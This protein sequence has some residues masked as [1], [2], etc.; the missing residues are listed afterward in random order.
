M[1]LQR[2][3]HP[4]SLPLCKNSKGSFSL[5][6]GSLIV[7]PLQVIIHSPEEHLEEFKKIMAHVIK[8]ATCDLSYDVRDRARF[9]S[10]LLPYSTTYLN[11][12]NSSCQSHNEDMFKELAN[13]I[14]DGKM[15]STFHP[16]NNYRIYLPGSLSQVVLHAAPG[17]APLPK[18]Q[19]MELIHKTMEPTR[20]VGNS[21]ES[22]NS[23][24]ESGSSTY[25]SG[26]VYDSESEV[27]GSSDRNAA[28]SNTKDNQEDPLVHVYDASVDQGQTARDVEDNFASLI[29]TDLT[30]LMSKSALE[31]WLDE[32]PAEPVQVSTQA[33]SAR[34]SFTNRSFERKPKLHMLLDPSNSN[35][36]SVL[37]AFSSEVS[38]VSR[39]LV[40]V[41]LLFENVST[42]QLADITI[43]SEEASGSEDG[44][45]QTLQG[46][47]RYYPSLIGSF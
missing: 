30:E 22:I 29:T 34:V 39:L 26:S 4:P 23:D 46:S 15:P 41:D 8:L 38:P 24:A 5:L 44:L 21:S 40:C 1:L 14:F 12:N 31:T 13:H 36:L 6:W 35:G 11:G 47:A 43:K 18:P 17:Y 45:D 16:T 33:S 42:N 32:A 25:D 3:L 27:D 37:Y 7:F 2:S 9:I 19:S 20:G 28:D 10:R